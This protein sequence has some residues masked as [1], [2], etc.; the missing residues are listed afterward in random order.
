MRS[1]PQT[2][3]AAV[4]A[5]SLAAACPSTR[6]ADEPSNL[7]ASALSALPPWARVEDPREL[8]RMDEYLAARNDPRLV[9]ESIH[10]GDD[11]DVDCVDVRLQHGFDA[12]IR[13]FACPPA[14]MD[15]R[16]P[17]AARD[18]ERQGEQ[19]YGG[20]TKRCP[21]GTIPRLHLTRDTLIRFE[22][23][24][25]FFRKYPQADPIHALRGPTELHQH[26]AFHQVDLRCVGAEAV[27]NLWSPST[28]LPSEFSLSQIWV[29]GGDGPDRETVEAGWQV[30]PDGY[31]SGAARVFVY[32]TPDDYTKGGCY[33]LDCNAFVQ[34]DSR[35]V[36]G[37]S[38]ARYSVADGEQ[39]AMR[40]E[41]RQN[42][43][44]D[45]WFRLDGAWIG[46][47]PNDRFDSR[48][49]ADAATRVAYGGEVMDYR[50]SGRHTKTQM[51]SGRFASAGWT[52]AAYQRNMTYV[53]GP[54][55]A[56]RRRQALPNATDIAGP[57]C[58]DAIY[59][60]DR[61]SAGWD[62][63]MFFGG[64]GFDPVLCW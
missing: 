52:K 26:A 23:L 11:E 64:R 25:A 29:V 1:V 47:W 36:L 33:N 53:E 60:F 6:D 16:V 44:G 38:F 37:G 13:E 4:V 2:A 31:G 7:A 50:S 10:V 62:T 63:Y 56:P 48:G 32:F 39:V 54:R 5:V 14:E 59:V 21:A 8:A 61:S 46:Y 27:L 41:L 45:W 40:V 24:D 9:R 30:Y 57:N 35:F 3:A 34:V 43:A 18:G 55:N 19:A 51:G 42:D 20:M 49:I 15:D 28:E 12:P 58:Y 22:S 17:G